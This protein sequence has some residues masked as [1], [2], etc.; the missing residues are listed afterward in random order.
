MRR[1]NLSIRIYERKYEIGNK[2][3]K[4][5]DL[6]RRIDKVSIRKLN[7]DRFFLLNYILY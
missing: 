1:R 3:L 6:L 2:E 7:S 5:I 4:R